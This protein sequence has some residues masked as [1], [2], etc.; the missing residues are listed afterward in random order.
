MRRGTREGNER[1][2]PSLDENLLGSVGG[3]GCGRD[4][5][6]GRQFLE[7]VIG[8][9]GDP[10]E[11]AWRL[12]RFLMISGHRLTVPIH[13]R[14]VGGSEEHAE[15][16]RFAGGG[17]DALCVAGVRR[18]R[19]TGPEMGLANMALERGISHITVG[20][21]LT[22]RHVRRR[23]RVHG[24]VAHLIAGEVCGGETIRVVCRGGK[25]GW[26]AGDD[27]LGRVGA[28]VGGVG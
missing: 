27:V 16:V 9:D 22:R 2:R 11:H 5:Y 26:H 14:I 21:G 17:V 6:I 13:G 20:R 24:G 3:T 10:A 23:E 7:G 19:S 15:I 1:N 28:G 8:A 25:T 18:S 12:S 4:S